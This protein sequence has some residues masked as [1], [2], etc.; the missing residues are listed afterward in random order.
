MTDKEEILKSVISEE[1]TKQLEEKKEDPL[2]EKK[3]EDEEELPVKKQEEKEI[4]KEIQKC[5]DMGV[6]EEKCWNIA[7]IFGYPREGEVQE[8]MSDDTYSPATQEDAV[9]MIE[10]RNQEI[11]SLKKSQIANKDLSTELDKVKAELCA[12]QDVIQAVRKAELEKYSDAIK[13]V[14]PE[15]KFMEQIKDLPHDTKIGLCKTFIQKFQASPE[16]QLSRD[17]VT[18]K[19]T[20]D[21]AAKGLFGMTESEI[22]EYYTGVK[23]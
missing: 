21:Q 1:V 18:G 3:E 15:G 19:S 13:K 14:D 17:D 16:V 9:E 8:K 11:S 5:V 12:A 6:D 22:L 10:T 23:A 20:R 4:P 7:G 2:T